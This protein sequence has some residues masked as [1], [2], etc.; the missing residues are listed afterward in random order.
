[1]K[2]A[3]PAEKDAGEPR[4]AA[5]PETVK[6]FIG[7]GAAV[8]VEPGAGVK[9]GIPDDEF[10]AAG[11]TI[12]A[13]AVSGADVV[14]KVRRP[15][16]AEIKFYKKGA[17]VAAIMDPYGNDAALKTLANA[18]VAAFAMELMPRI[19]RAQ[20]MDVLSSQANLAG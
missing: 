11:A 6:K 10:K 18:G 20:S 7:L 14:L 1:M 3:I 15:N 19:T 16:E 5:T 9:S 13:D 12:A 4:V 17:V 8:A 2:I